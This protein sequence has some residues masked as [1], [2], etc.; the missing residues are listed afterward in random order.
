MNK[1]RQYP[2]NGGSCH[3]WPVRYGM[4]YLCIRFDGQK[5]TDWID[6]IQHTDKVINKNETGNIKKGPR[7]AIFI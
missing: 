1:C 2:S 4:C 6:A 5:E 7:G 3:R